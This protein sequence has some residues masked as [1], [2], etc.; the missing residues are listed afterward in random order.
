MTESLNIALSSRGTPGIQIMIPRASSTRRPGA[1]PFGF[2]I[3][4]ASRGTMACFL[5]FSVRR[6]LYRAN[7]DSISSKI[8]S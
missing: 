6:R 7:I 3:M 4:V 2:S 8:S 1:V 5:L